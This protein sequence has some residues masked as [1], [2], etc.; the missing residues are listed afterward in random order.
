M[1]GF[2]RPNKT[3]IL[4][5]AGGS[6]SGKTY[7]AQAL[8]EALGD[9]AVIVYQDNFYID[10]SHR[11]DHDG[12]SVNFDHPESLDLRLLASCLAELKTCQDT[13]IPVYDFKTHT[14]LRDQLRVSATAVVI[15]DGILIFHPDYLRDQFDEMIFFDTPESLRF[16]R[17]LER[18]VSER[19][20]TPEGVKAQFLNQ[21]KPMHDQFVEPSK[22]HAHTIVKDLGD[23]HEH[24]DAYKEKLFKLVR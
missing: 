20:R 21:V 15:V 10:Q 4:G 22:L 16:Q 24:F 1:T 13:N 6:G 5:V 17:R 2:T 23:Y 9:Q 8:K 18:D 19:G 12:G 7:F 14:R 3:F 11:F